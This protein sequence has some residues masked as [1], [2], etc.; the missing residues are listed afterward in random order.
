MVVTRS[1]SQIGKS[2]ARPVYSSVHKIENVAESRVAIRS[3]HKP[4]YT[5]KT[6][7]NNYLMKELC[8]KLVSR[9]ANR[10]TTALVLDASDS[11]T[12]K[13][14]VAK[15]ALPKKIYVPNPDRLTSDKIKRSGFSAVCMTAY[16]FLRHCAKVVFTIV[17]LDYCHTWCGNK[18]SQTSMADDIGLMFEKKLLADNGTFAVTVSMRGSLLDPMSGNG[19][20]G[21]KDYIVREICFMAMQNGYHI[22]LREQ[23]SF[24]H[25]KRRGDKVYKRDVASCASMLFLIFDVRKID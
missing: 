17:Y 14:L 6:Q 21:N 4:T 18:K 20:H 3:V 5:I 8:N 25:G 13:I 11:Q 7:E 15:G 24:F 19:I 1:G 16:S 22:V 10:A 9:N 2:C 12:S 23:D